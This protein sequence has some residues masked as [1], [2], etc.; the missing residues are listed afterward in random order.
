MIED[1]LEHADISRGPAARDYSDRL[2]AREIYRLRAMLDLGLENVDVAREMA[3]NR[4]AVMYHRRLYDAELAKAGRSPTAPMR[5]GRLTG[6]RLPATQAARLRTLLLKGVPADAAA[7]AMEVSKTCA[8]RYRMEIVHDLASRGRT[9]PGCDATGRVIGRRS[10]NAIAPDV[11]ADIERRLIIP[12]R[13]PAIAAATG[14]SAVT[15][16][17]IWKDMKPTLASMPS[18]PC[19]KE[20]HHPQRCRPGTGLD[21]RS[22][23]EALR[24]MVEEAIPRHHD[25]ALRSDMV[26]DVVTEILGL[27]RPPADMRGV[28]RRV[29]SANYRRFANKWGDLSLDAPLGDESGRTLLDVVAH[30]TDQD[31]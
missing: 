29:V 7:I 27:P 3:L 13:V 5:A 17:R 10:P 24:R 2:P 25:P 23:G 12:E 31:R 11:T 26:Q 4:T 20:A 6:R 9:L 14:V 18:C 28:V 21:P 8:T 22:D 16:R 15:I 19:G 30:R 1:L